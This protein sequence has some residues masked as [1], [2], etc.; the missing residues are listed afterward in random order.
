MTPLSVDPITFGR[1]QV[2][3][4]MTSVTYDSIK[5]IAVSIRNYIGYQNDLTSVA[6]T[7]GSSKKGVNP[8]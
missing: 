6:K 1:E 4:Y 7:I 3:P 5:K 8:I 2:I